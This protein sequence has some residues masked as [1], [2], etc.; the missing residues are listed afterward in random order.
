MLAEGRD[1]MIEKLA[2]ARKQQ[3]E[4]RTVGDGMSEFIEAQKPAWRASTITANES[5]A[6]TM[7]LAE[8]GIGSR[9][10]ATLTAAE[11]VSWRQ[12][13]RTR[14]PQRGRK[15]RMLLAQSIER[16][17]AL[18]QRDASLKNL[19]SWSVL[20]HALPAASKVRPVE[21]PRFVAGDEVTIFWTALAEHSGAGAGALRLI[22]VTGVRHSEATCAEWSEFAL[23]GA[24]PLWAIAAARTKQCGAPVG[25]LSPAAVTVLRR[26][27]AVARGPF[28][29][30]GIRARSPIPPTTM[31]APWKRMGG[32]W[33]ARVTPH[34]LRASRRSW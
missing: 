31:A 26:M 4:G 29:C 14:T 34:D 18:G 12:P 17:E 23:D 25:P 15:M 22:V 3:R 27:Q 11:V 24:E 19:A 5:L 21:H 30:S 33:A 1:P 20:R 16:A 28:V 13:I 32:D 10:L 9:P 7:N 8:G 6:R 2:F